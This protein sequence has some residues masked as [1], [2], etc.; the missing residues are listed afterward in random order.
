MLANYVHAITAERPEITT[1]AAAE[2]CGAHH[3]L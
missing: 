3:P 1:A 2:F